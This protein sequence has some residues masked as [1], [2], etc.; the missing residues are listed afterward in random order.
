MKR[1]WIL[2]AGAIPLAL[3]TPADA[4]SNRGY[5]G[6]IV[7]RT[8]H[9]A[10]FIGA[11]HRVGNSN[12]FSRN[13]VRGK[14]NHA[15]RGHLNRGRFFANNFRYRPGLRRGHVINH[16]NHRHPY[17]WKRALWGG[18]WWNNRY[19]DHDFKKNR[20]RHKHQVRNGWWFD[21]FDRR[22][23]RK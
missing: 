14:V 3:A 11:G 6:P 7:H 10:G 16:R 22:V 1:F 12:R 13:H 18:P 20:K 15:R 8:S 21:R 2:F 5:T 4:G 17:W 9:Q 23:D 19:R